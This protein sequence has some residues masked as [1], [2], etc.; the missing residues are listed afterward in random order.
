V[1]TDYYI[2]VGDLSEKIDNMEWKL[3]KFYDA[4][5]GPAPSLNE[6]TKLGFEQDLLK[7]QKIYHTLL[8][9]IKDP[10]GVEHIKYLIGEKRL[11]NVKTIESEPAFNKW[12]EKI[13]EYIHMPSDTNCIQGKTA[14]GRTFYAF[15]I[16]A[17]EGCGKIVVIG[18]KVFNSTTWV[19]AADHVPTRFSG[20]ILQSGAPEP[21]YYPFA[22]TLFSGEKADFAVVTI[23]LDE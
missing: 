21:Q 13:A 23:R 15:K 8:D 17:N 3:G 20:H 14:D 2:Q 16:I 1:N 9:S 22:K 7:L 6:K 18:Q 4:A 12:Y 5:K 19:I 11:E 10:I